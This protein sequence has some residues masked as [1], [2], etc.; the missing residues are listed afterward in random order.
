MNEQ[1]KITENDRRSGLNR[2]LGAILYY[3]QNNKEIKVCKDCIHSI[4][5]SGN[6]NLKVY[7]CNRKQKIDI[8]SGKPELTPCYHER[9]NSLFKCGE[10]AKYFISKQKDQETNNKTM[11][12]G[13]KN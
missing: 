7:W 5:I 13:E 11:Q 9:Q 12:N 8:V 6:K 4:D 3:G 10:K 2:W 1:T